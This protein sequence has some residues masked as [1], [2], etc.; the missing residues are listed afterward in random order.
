MSVYVK[1]FHEQNHIILYSNSFKTFDLSIRYSLGYSSIWNN[2]I[3]Q[4][5]FWKSA[6]CLTWYVCNVYGGEKAFY[7]CKRAFRSHWKYRR[8][9]TW[10]PIAIMF[11]NTGKPREDESSWEPELYFPKSPQLLQY[12]MISLYEKIKRE[13]QIWYWEWMKF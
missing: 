4:T 8:N 9:T 12:H 5:G 11:I 6:S 2:V 3:A 10:N 7:C 1:Y 13:Q